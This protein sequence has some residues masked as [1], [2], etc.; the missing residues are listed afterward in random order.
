MELRKCGTAGLALPALGVGCWAFGG[1]EYWGSQDQGDV[2]AVV[3]AAIDAGCNYFDSAE[4]YNNGASE[5]SLGTAL[6]GV[7]H[8]AIV[9]TKVSPSNCYA[10]TLREHCE[11][12]LRRLRTNYIDLYMVHWPIHPHSIRHFT[13]DEK[14][15]GNPPRVEEAFDTLN[16]LRQEGKIRHIGVSNFGPGDWPRRCDMRRSQSTNCPTAC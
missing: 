4:V 12:S 11:Q 3:H 13:N 9:G 8:R 15:I 14:V 10:A 6:E 5:S 2:D 1:G 16:R 7:R